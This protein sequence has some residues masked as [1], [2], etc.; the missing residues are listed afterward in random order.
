MDD[1]LAELRRQVDDDTQS[2]EALI[3]A[4]ADAARV[5]T[6]ADGVAI[7][8]RSRGAVVC[9]ARSGE[10]APEVGTPLNLQS[11]ISGECLR[12]ASILLCSDALNDSRV[13]AEVCRSMGIGSL[14]AVPLRGAIGTAGILEAFC[15][16]TNAFG[17]EQIDTLREL[18]KIAESAYQRERRALEDE[19]LTQLRGAR[20]LSNLFNNKG[21]ESNSTVEISAPSVDDLSTGISGTF[22]IRK[23]WVLGMLVLAVLM[24]LGVW[25]SWRE[26]LTDLNDAQR[27]AS[28]HPTAENVPSNPQE[29]ALPGLKAAVVHKEQDRQASHAVVKPAAVIEAADSGAE[30]VSTS[31]MDT[32]ANARRAD[33]RGPSPSR[34]PSD[35]GEQIA[36]PQIA[37]NGGGPSPVAALVADREALPKMDAAI[38]T[39]V[40][41][42]ELIHK[43]EPVYPMQARAQRIS[44]SVVLQIT[45]G[46]DGT[47]REMKTI[48]GDSLLAAS[49]REAIR[50][51]R[52]RPVLLNGKP[53][54]ADKQVTVLFKLP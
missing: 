29:T 9:R 28:S 32:P 20:R 30:E 37:I 26:P 39:G 52:Y 44:G 13:D 24:V 53:I 6:A 15:N 31:W 33:S 48:S 2:P 10:L 40:T 35:L 17:E 54:E 7:A 22:S 42:G 51:W 45:I 1:T 49:A 50:Q 47:V 4:T 46:T 27:K 18:A 23:Y 3:S 19:T 36:P 11:G 8:L 16:R 5:L 14:I 41:Q 38:S 34:P 21:A 25:L 43:V 12:S